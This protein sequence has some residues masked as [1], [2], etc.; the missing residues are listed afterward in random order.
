M[1]KNKAEKK[2]E[3]K[4]KAKTGTVEGATTAA[5][6]RGTS[7]PGKELSSKDYAAS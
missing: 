6:E 1:G 5:D 3:G 4:G 2:D 7:P